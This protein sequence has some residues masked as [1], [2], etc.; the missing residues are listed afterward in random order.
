M[1]EF[2]SFAMICLGSAS[3]AF[4]AA[5]TAVAQDAATPPLSSILHDADNAVVYDIESRAFF[6]WDSESLDALSINVSSIYTVE[7]EE[8]VTVAGVAMIPLSEA[9]DGRLAIPCDQ[10]VVPMPP[11]CRQERV[12]ESRSAPAAMTKRRGRTGAVRGAPGGQSEA[13][14]RSSSLPRCPLDPR[15]PA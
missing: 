6:A 8:L 7:P 15:C 5:C 11:A 10:F 1:K 12:S 14:G 4:L 9:H 13:E 2:E 3:F